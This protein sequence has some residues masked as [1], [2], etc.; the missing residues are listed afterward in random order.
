MKSSRYRRRPVCFLTHTQ[1][2]RPHLLAHWFTLEVAPLDFCR[3]KP[4]RADVTELRE[5]RSLLI[6]DL[7]YFVDQFVRIQKSMVVS[8]CVCRWL[9]GYTM[10]D[11]P[12]SSSVRRSIQLPLATSPCLH[13]LNGDHQCAL[14]AFV[15]PISTSSLL[16]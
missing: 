3:F 11:L 5:T 9:P 2:A 8:V 15:R 12:P 7:S 6:C 4:G 16:S 10:L 1:Y 13:P 14:V